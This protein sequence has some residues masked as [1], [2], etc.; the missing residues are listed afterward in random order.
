M[1]SIVLL[2]IPWENNK[3]GEDAEASIPSSHLEE[4]ATSLG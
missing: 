2:H 3:F 1:Y 4:L